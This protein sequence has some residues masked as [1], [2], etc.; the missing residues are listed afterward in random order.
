MTF[1]LLESDNV[2]DQFDYDIL[3][4]ISGEM[5]RHNKLSFSNSFP[6]LGLSLTVTT[7]F[8][9]VNHGPIRGYRFEATINRAGRV[10]NC[11]Y[12]YEPDE[13]GTYEEAVQAMME[14]INQKTS[15]NN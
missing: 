3:I 4:F 6:D 7:S 2:T 8:E 10:I 13:I 14:Q 12:L 1:V 15:V 9:E 11:N 5:T